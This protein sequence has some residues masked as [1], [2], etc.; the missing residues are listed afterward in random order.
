MLE[1]I[2]HL[3]QAPHWC[4]GCNCMTSAAGQLLCLLLLTSATGPFSSSS[5]AASC[6][7]ASI[8]IFTTSEAWHCAALFRVLLGASSSS[9]FPPSCFV[10]KQETC[11]LA[12]AILNYAC[13]KASRRRPRD[14]TSCPASGAAPPGLKRSAAHIAPS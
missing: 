5:S 1:T 3:K 9:H 7:L 8:G 13:S 10:S 14:A 4:T 2:I 12:A 6:V 11:A